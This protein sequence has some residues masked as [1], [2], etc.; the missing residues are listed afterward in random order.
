MG[1]S[2]Q[3]VFGRSDRSLLEA[4]AFDGVRPPSGEGARELWPRPGG[5]QMLRFSDD[6]W[7]LEQLRGLVEWSGAPAC[8]AMVH[9]SDVAYVVGLDPNGREWQA[10]LGLEVAADMGISRPQDVYDDLE[11]IASPQYTEAVAAERAALEATVPAAAEAA[12]A[13]AAAAGVATAAA[14]GVI[15]DVLRSHEVFVEDSFIALIDALGFPP[16]IAP[17]RGGEA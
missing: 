4:G 2:G 7:G 15:E 11:W 5:W 8:L 14:Q 12:I 13:W 1:F 10:V 6:R 17:A 16:A 3:F 9:D